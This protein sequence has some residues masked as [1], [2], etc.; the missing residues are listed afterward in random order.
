M[1]AYGWSP[2]PNPQPWFYKTSADLGRHEGQN[3][4]NELNVF[5]SRFESDNLV[6]E[7]KQMEASLQISPA[8]ELMMPFLL[9][10]TWSTDI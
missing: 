7:V 9:S 8:E 2:E 10:S 6:S 1:C 5:F 3:M 4:A